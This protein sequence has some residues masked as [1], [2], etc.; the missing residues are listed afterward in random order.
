MEVDLKDAPR[1]DLLAT[2]ACP[3]VVQ[4]IDG[5]EHLLVFKHPLAGY[6]LVKGTIELGE[7]PSHAAVRE[8]A[9]ESG[10][11]NAQAVRDLGSWDAGYEQQIWSFQLCEV[12]ESL[13]HQWSF[14][15]HDDGG[16]VFDFFWHPLKADLPTPCH[17]LFQAAWTQ[18][19]NRLCSTDSSE[20]RDIRFMQLAL[21]NGR[22]ALPGCLPNPPVG[23]VIT[24][25]GEVVASGFTQVPGRHHAEAMALS[26]LSPGLEGLTAYVTLEPCSFFGRTPSCAHALV[27][28]GVQRVVVA[29]LDPDPRNSGAG[30]T[31]LRQANVNV[32]VG[33]LEEEARKDMGAYVRST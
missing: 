23:C 1:S 33:L 22:R 29:M 15:T 32:C 2:K 10:I 26:Q 30:I 12:A 18:I 6:Q 19:R 17:A 11:S 25:D 9:E 31:I 14:D 27:A 5:M 28:A 3:V 13:P 20:L 8:L 24:L 7:R 16:H 21:A 4:I